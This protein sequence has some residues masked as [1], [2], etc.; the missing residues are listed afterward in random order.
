MG[1]SENPQE[2]PQFFDGK[3]TWLP[4]DLSGPRQPLIL[5][6]MFRSGGMFRTPVLDSL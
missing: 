6:Q 3:D 5:D 4:A 1:K 2:N